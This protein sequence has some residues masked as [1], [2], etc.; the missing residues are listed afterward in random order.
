MAVFSVGIDRQDVES[1]VPVDQRDDPVVNDDD[2]QGAKGALPDAALGRRVELAL[3]AGAFHQIG[4]HAHV[5]VNGVEAGERLGGRMNLLLGLRVNSAS[6][7][8]CSTVALDI[9]RPTMAVKA[10]STIAIPAEVRTQRS[11]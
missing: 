1:S 8:S 2:R 3:L 5:L 10:S 4:Q 11:S 6:R 7:R 9:D